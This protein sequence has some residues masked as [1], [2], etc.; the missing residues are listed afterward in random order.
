[1]R[2]LSR[3]ADERGAAALE[4]G[5]VIP[6]ILMLIFGIIQYGFMYWSLQ[7]A[8]ATA[9][10]AARSLIVGTTEACTLDRAEELADNP[11]VGGGAPVAVARYF[12]TTGAATT[13]PVQGGLV[14]VQVSLT[15]LD[16]NMPFLPLPDG[17]NVVQTAQ[18]RVENVPPVPLPCT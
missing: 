12:D 1:V 10:E 13:G 3:R 18:A 11:A 9:R 17:G 5:L 16:L 6:V 7:T 14:E 4:F 2:R 8:S 15:T